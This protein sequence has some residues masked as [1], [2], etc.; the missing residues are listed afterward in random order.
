MFLLKHKTQQTQQPLEDNT[1]TPSVYQSICW[2]ATC[3][4]IT[5]RQVFSHRATNTQSVQL[6][7]P[8]KKQIHACRDQSETDNLT[9]KKDTL[10]RVT[11]C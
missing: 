4:S 2:M 8:F 3:N 9:L 5:Q 1:F 7:H 6:C 11:R 10:G